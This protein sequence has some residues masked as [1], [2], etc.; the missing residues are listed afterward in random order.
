MILY[1]CYIYIFKYFIGRLK[2]NKKK[3]KQITLDGFQRKLYVC[4]CRKIVY[5]PVIHDSPVRRPITKGKR[6]EGETKEEEE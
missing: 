6:R 4:M 2:V 3:V 1:F 5:R